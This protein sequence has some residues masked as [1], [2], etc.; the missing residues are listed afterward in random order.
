MRFLI[1]T[2]ASGIPGCLFL[3]LRNTDHP[4]TLTDGIPE[5]NPLKSCQL[6]SRDPDALPFCHA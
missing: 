2:F 4:G 5:K 3:G 6:H 1:P